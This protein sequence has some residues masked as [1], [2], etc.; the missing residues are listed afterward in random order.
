[1]HN[2]WTHIEGPVSVLTAGARRCVMMAGCSCC[3]D[4][5]IFQHISCWLYTS[6]D[7]FELAGSILLVSCLH[8]RLHYVQGAV[9]FFHPSIRSCVSIGPKEIPSSS[10]TIF[11]FFSFLPPF[12]FSR[13]VSPVGLTRGESSFLSFFFPHLERHQV[14]SSSAVSTS[15]PAGWHCCS[16]T[17]RLAVGPL[18]LS[19]FHDHIGRPRSKMFPSRKKT[20]SSSGWMRRFHRRLPSC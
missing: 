6:F 14:S 9:R 12:F 8:A 4:F 13:G 2:G 16:S 11:F 10:K 18:A 3:F 20:R 7:W 19:E 1:M 5:N 17:D 15:V